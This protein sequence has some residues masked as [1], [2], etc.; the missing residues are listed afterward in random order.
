MLSISVHGKG[1]HLC[2]MHWGIPLVLDFAFLIWAL[3]VP[4]ATLLVAVCKLWL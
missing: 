4:E 2:S 3:K 1:F